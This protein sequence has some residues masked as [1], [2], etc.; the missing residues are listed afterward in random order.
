MSSEHETLVGAFGALEAIGPLRRRWVS[1]ARPTVNRAQADLAD[2][3]HRFVVAIG[4]NKQSA[5]E[6]IVLTDRRIGVIGSEG[7]RWHSRDEVWEVSGVAVSPVAGETLSVYGNDWEHVWT[8]VR[9]LGAAPG[10][11]QSLRQQLWQKQSRV[12]PVGH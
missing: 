9:P 10:M 2:D 4:E 8:Q 6:G 1:S 7:C 3:E 5:L 11:V 12:E